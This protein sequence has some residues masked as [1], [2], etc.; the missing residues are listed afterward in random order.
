M[1]LKT[2]TKEDDTVL[3]EIQYQKGVKYLCENGI[4]KVPKK[5]IWPVSD[6]PNVNDGELNELK[7][8]LNLPIIDLAELQ[9]SNRP[10]V[11]ESLANACQQYG[12]FQVR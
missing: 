2:E 8:N 10:Q 5:Y 12:F 6:R 1:A 4:D 7:K 3:P 11:L 9:G